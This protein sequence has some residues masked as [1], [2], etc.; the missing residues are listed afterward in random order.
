MVKRIRLQPHLTTDELARRY[1]A[2]RDP[3]ER[4]HYQ[5]I[6]LIASG[7]ATS[8]VMEATGYSRGWVQEA[9]RRYNRQGPAGLGDRRRQN[10]GGAAL[11][12]EAGKQELRGALAGDARDGGLW[13]G[14]KVAAWIA[15]KLGR[16]VSERVGWL[17]LRRVGYRPKVPRPA[18][19]AA[20]AEEQARFPK[21]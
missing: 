14:P 20:D 4:T 8:A 5:L 6:W 16:T 7:Q 21:G 3:V 15:Q 11:L 10:P 2:A 13:S 17:Y 9:A 19:E 1:R 18:H 12:D